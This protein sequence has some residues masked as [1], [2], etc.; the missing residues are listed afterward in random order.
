MVG[1]VASDLS[2][3]V[4]G[5]D[6]SYWTLCDEVDMYK[7]KLIWYGFILTVKYWRQPDGAKFGDWQS[8]R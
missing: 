8:Y 7:N 3:K 4:E 2:L 5:L 6:A 1:I